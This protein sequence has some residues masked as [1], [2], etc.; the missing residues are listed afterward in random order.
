MTDELSAIRTDLSEWGDTLGPCACATLC[1]KGTYN[2]I[3]ESTLHSMQVC[4]V[5][6]PLPTYSGR[7]LC[8]RNAGLALSLNFRAFGA[9][10]SILLRIVTFGGIVLYFFYKRLS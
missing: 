8:L 4:W 6:V 5:S 2:T 9:F 1:G 7:A 10:R 3:Q